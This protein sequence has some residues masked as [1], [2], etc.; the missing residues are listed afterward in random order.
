[1]VWLYAGILLWNV[2]AV[3]SFTV[4]SSV[5]LFSLLLISLLAGD[6][7]IYLVL[8][9]NNKFSNLPTKLLLGFICINTATFL[10][11][12]ILPFGLAWDWLALIAIVGVLWIKYRWPESRK[13]LLIRNNSEALFLLF[14]P[15]AIIAWNQDFLRPIEIGK[16]FAVIRSWSDIYFHLA[17]INNLALSKGIFSMTDVQAAGLPAHIYHIASYV[18]PATLAN[19]TGLSSLEAYSSLYVPIGI[20]LTALAAYAL[21][22][23]I[24]GEWPALVASLALLMLPDASQQG[25]GNQFLSYHWMQLIGPAGL[26]GVSLAAT[27]FLFLF[28]GYQEKKYKLII[29]GYIF[30]GLVLFY[31]AQIFVA[32]SFLA[33]IFPALFISGVALR[34]RLFLLIALTSIYFGILTIS[35][36]F[37][38][39][40]VILLDGSGL[41]WYGAF[42]FNT[43]SYSFIREL[44]KIIFTKN[45]NFFIE[46]IALIGLIATCTFGVYL[47]IYLSLIKYLRNNFDYAVWIFPSL[48]LIIYFIMATCL[49]LDTR[50]IG[51]PEELLHR[52]FV[53]AYFII[54]IWGAG[55]LYY[56]YCGDSLPTSNAVSVCLLVI[57]ALM[58]ISPIYF[59]Q[60]IQTYKQ[61]NMGYQK[62]PLCQLE[63]AKFIKKNSDVNDI[64]QD[65][66]ND[67][68][69]ILSAL[70]ERKIFA[71]DTGG[72]RQPLGI[73]SRLRDLA[74]LRGLRDHIPV[75]I[76][77]KNNSIKWY[78]VNPRTEV[79]WAELASEHKV[80]ECGGYKIYN[81]H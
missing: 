57:T 43:H 55:G 41:S 56:R 35:Q 72:I 7:F 37:Q 52:H 10:M 23:S 33:F 74:D 19:T 22:N 6:L 54:V 15:L 58:L 16:E 2:L 69:L 48:V 17:Q 31:K 25:F 28:A 20:L 36:S 4:N 75:E 30:A 47:F 65:S 29:L 3:G 39:V 13:V 18:L 26:Y 68:S 66:A 34:L 64:I 24:F 63:S 40:P 77:M 27:A 71:I 11:A 1:M 61:W 50:N 79:Q 73:Q 49:A 45:S 14:S 44:G 46:A 21:I 78:V 32:I 81:F 59:G 53:W 70:S 12:L 76:F 80:F 51:M 8:G 42:V 38:G 60:E 67:P 9:Q 62:I 5:W